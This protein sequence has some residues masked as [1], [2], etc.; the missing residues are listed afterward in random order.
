MNTSACNATSAEASTAAANISALIVS[1]ILTVLGAAVLAYA[2]VVQRYGLAH[3]QRYITICGCR[4]HRLLVW[5]VGIV[6]YGV[7]N[8]LKVTAFNLGPLTVLGSVFSIVLVFN[9]IFASWLLKEEITWPK[10]ASSLTILGGAII[11]TIGAPLETK[12]V[13]TP[14]DI[15]TLLAGHPGFVTVLAVLMTFALM[16]VVAFECRYPMT[17]E[18]RAAVAGKGTPLS[19]VAAEQPIGHAAADE[20]THSS[21]ASGAEAGVAGVSVL[22]A[23][24]SST[25]SK[26]SGAATPLLLRPSSRLDAIMAV[27]YPGGLGLDEALADLLIRA[28]T[29]MLAACTGGRGCA[30]CG[31]PVV[32]VSIGLWVLLS[33]GGSL[34]WMPIVYKRYEVS[35]ALP[36]E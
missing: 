31:V 12:N 8:G 22:P 19:G 30:D 13:F 29:A 32:Y 2:M 27:V 23:D 14:D 11:C 15:S 18:V 3:P 24:G 25:A 33:F 34:L 7:A 10:I 16:A 21:A 36:I 9:L 4:W 28:W 20:K 26:S 17:A 1:I 5:F 6:L 35:V